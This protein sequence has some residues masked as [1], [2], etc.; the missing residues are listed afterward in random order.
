MAGSGRCRVPPGRSHGYVDL[1]IMQSDTQPITDAD[2]RHRPHDAAVAVEGNGIAAFQRR[3]RAEGVERAGKTGQVRHLML[4]AAHAGRLQAMAGMLGT[5]TQQG[6]AL[7]RRRPLQAQMQLRQ[8]LPS[9]R[10]QRRGQPDQTR[11]TAAQA[12]AEPVQMRERMPRLQS[13]QRQE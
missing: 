13:Q 2:W 11:M 6:D 1:S 4:N 5:P 9:L 8:A 3:Q 12:I 7:Q 10:E